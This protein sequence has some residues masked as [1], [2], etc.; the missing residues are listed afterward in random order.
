MYSTFLCLQS[1]VEFNWDLGVNDITMLRLSRSGLTEHTQVVRYRVPK[2][3][4][5]IP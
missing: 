5:T 1:H 4:C 3:L 2:K